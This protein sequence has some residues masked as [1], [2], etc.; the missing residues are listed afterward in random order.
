MKMA[1]NTSGARNALR[2]VAIMAGALA[3]LALPLAGCG[4]DDGKSS[5]KKS[6]AAPSPTARQA[7]TVNIADFK[8]KP[9]PITVKAGG[10][11]TFVNKDKAFHTAQTELNPKTAEF[12]TAKLEKGD[13]KAVT[14]EHPGKFK[15]FCAYHRFMEG[16]VEVVR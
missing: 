12:D 16:T 6:A 13:R 1:R 8:F 11:V 2:A 14:L 7:V 15:Y 5:P 3:L 9:D 4:G 10:T